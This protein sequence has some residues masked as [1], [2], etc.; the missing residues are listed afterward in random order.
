MG[1]DLDR[2]LWHGQRPWFEVWFAVVL[3][4]SRKRALW[5]RQTMFVPKQGDGRTTV[6][7]AWFDADSATPSRAAK[8]YASI[9]PLLP[10]LV[11]PTIPP[12]TPD[13]SLSR[14]FRQQ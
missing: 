7:A 8:H 6:W 13:T 14:P 3:D 1:R 11:L 12:V 4:A 10:T 9:R 5:I 2:P